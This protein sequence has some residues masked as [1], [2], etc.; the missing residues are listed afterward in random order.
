MRA[1]GVPVGYV[2]LDD[3][4]YEGRVYEGAVS[5]VHAWEPRADWFPSATPSGLRTLGVPTMLYM[6]YFCASAA[7]R[8]PQVELLR[9][10]GR[11]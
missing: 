9:G 7:S 1:Q 10:K 11:A 8:Y 6:P 3:W 2:Q 5:C 4:W